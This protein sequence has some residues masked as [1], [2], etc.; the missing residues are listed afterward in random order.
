MRLEITRR[1]DLAVRAMVLLGDSPVRWK[2]PA[3]A[4]A[5]DTTTGFVPQVLGPLVKAGW[6]RSEPG[7][8]GGYIAAVTL[9]DVSVLQVVEVIDGA[10][11]DGRCVV[12]N[13]LCSADQP[14]AMHHAWSRA[15]GELMQS[16]AATPLSSLSTGGVSSGVAR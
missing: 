12:E 7:P 5:L 13:R 14:C 16:L 2:A 8:T 4:K 15:R 11:D 3:L 6:V 1:A 10:T 9:A